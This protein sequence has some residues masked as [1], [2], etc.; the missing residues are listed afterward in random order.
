MEAVYSPAEDSWLL[1]DY[2]K[3]ENL[4]EK[5]CL[6]LGCG[7]GI[8]AIAM[9]KAGAKEVL[10]IDV[11]ESALKETNINIDK[12]FDEYSKNKS[13]IVG[14]F[15]GAKK[16]DLFSAVN[17]KFDFISFN[18]PYV[19]SDEIKWRDLDGGKNGRI[20]I[21]RFISEVKNHL[22]PNGIVILLISSLNDVNSVVSKFKNLGFSVSI[23]SKKKLFF[24]ELIILRAN[25]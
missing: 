11:N 22:N 24:E 18:P 14:H 12:F 17:D 19:P 23:E 4:S 20:V 3:K 5:K 1:G 9:L 7:S 10:S 8:L 15:V 25:I 6:D 13:L 2:L 16:S 21:D